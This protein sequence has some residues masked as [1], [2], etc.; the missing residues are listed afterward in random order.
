MVHQ[1]QRRAAECRA[2]SLPAARGSVHGCHADIW[3]AGGSSLK[4][5]HAHREA[6]SLQLPVNVCGHSSVHRKANEARLHLMAQA[7][8]AVLV[9]SLHS[10][11]QSVHRTGCVASTGSIC[12][13]SSTCQAARFTGISQAAAYWQPSSE[14]SSA[15][16]CIPV[17]SLTCLERT[18]N[19]GCHTTAVPAPKLST[20]S[21][22]PFT[23][24]PAVTGALCCAPHAM[25]PAS[26]R[27]MACSLGSSSCCKRFDR[28]VPFHFLLACQTQNAFK[29]CVF[30]TLVK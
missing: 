4:P 21:L 30:G 25:C 7:P 24:A 16:A 5:A 9:Q 1:R 22:E 2:R 27:K 17:L 18:S 10:R 26:E 6:H 11:Y 8:V 20:R 14:P 13:A 12:S 19:P 23:Y 3:W 29:L 28:N 15:Y